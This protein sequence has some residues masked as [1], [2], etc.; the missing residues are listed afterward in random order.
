MRKHADVC[1][2]L[3]GTYPFVTGGVSNWSHELI[4]EQNH[5][6]F[7]LVAIVPHDA[8]LELKYKLP[9]NVASLT[10]IRLGELPEGAS[11]SPL[12]ARRLHN[13]L[14][15]PLARVMSDQPLELEP[16]KSVLILSTDQFNDV[17]IST[18]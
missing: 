9:G 11:T 16:G 8:K 14:K 12:L 2:I 6:S 10:T 7:H 17:F 3:E 1:L 4:M 18:E 5:L 15:E 13:T